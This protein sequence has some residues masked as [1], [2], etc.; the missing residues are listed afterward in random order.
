MT[1]IPPSRVVNGGSPLPHRSVAP[2]PEDC[3][4][5]QCIAFQ[6]RRAAD[7]LPATALIAAHDRDRR[8]PSG[9]PKVSALGR[10]PAAGAPVGYRA[11]SQR[12][13][14]RRKLLGSPRRRAGVV[15]PLE[16]SARLET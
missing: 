16:E 14:Q 2:S 1:V 12:R 5:D 9:K 15:Q 11:V 10:V 7:R 6:E 13:R 8:T 3:A 4:S